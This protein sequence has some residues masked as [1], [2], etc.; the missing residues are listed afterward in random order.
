VADWERGGGVSD[1]PFFREFA[2]GDVFAFALRR[3]TDEE[4]GKRQPAWRLIDEEDNGLVIPAQKE[5]LQDVHETTGVGF[6]QSELASAFA[7][8][9]YGTI[10]KA[11]DY[12]TRA[13]VSTK[14][15]QAVFNLVKAKVKQDEDQWLEIATAAYCALPMPRPQIMEYADMGK[16]AKLDAVSSG[17]VSFFFQS[18]SRKKMIP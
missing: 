5:Q 11:A 1:G 16:R 8:R 18:L 12:L 9:N 10:F 3:A 13:L 15:T 4:A 6:L 17:G 2:V 14:A 7:S